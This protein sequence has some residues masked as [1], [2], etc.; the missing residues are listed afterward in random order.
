MKVTKLVLAAVLGGATTFGLF[1]LMNSLVNNPMEAPDEQKSVKI[2]DLKMPNTKIENRFEEAKPEKPEEPEAPPPELPEPEFV[3]PDANMG[4]INMDVPIASAE[5]G[6][7]GMGGLNMGEGDMIPIVKAAYEY[8]TSASSRGIE[9]SCEVVFT[10]TETGS[11]IDA[12]ADEAK[13]MTSEGKPTSVFNRSS[14]KAALKFKYK[15]RVVDGKPVAV[16]NV[17]NKFV[18]QLAKD[19]KKR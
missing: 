9:G 11:V 17:R 18:Y 1:T 2:P 12:V 15:P 19:E 13:C 8:P 7:G 14:V 6:V 5:L 16:P 4:G 10:V 3:A